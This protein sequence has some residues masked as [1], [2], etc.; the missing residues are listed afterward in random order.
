[1][2]RIATDWLSWP[3]PDIRPGDICWLRNTEAG[4]A[5]GNAVLERESRIVTVGGV[6]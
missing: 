1:V 2:I 6:I 4:D 3:D 5:I